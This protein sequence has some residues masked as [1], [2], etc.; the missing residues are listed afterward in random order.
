VLSLAAAV[1]LATV[2]TVLAVWGDV[3]SW[4]ALCQLLPIAR[5]LPRSTSCR[6][7]STP[8]AHSK[9]SGGFP[10]RPKRLL[11][12][13]ART[14]PKPVKAK[15]LAPPPR[16]AR[17]APSPPNT[18]VR[19]RPYVYM[20]ARTNFVL[21][22]AKLL[23]P[24]ACAATTGTAATDKNHQRFWLVPTTRTLALATRPV[25]SGQNGSF[26]P[27]LDALPSGAIER[28]HHSS[29]EHLLVRQLSLHPACTNRAEEATACV[30]AA[31]LT[32]KCHE[33][34]RLC[35]DRRL[36]VISFFDPDL[37]FYRG[38]FPTY[39]A[40]LWGCHAPSSGNCS[41]RPAF[42]PTRI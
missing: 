19:V 21:E 41:V 30:I 22:P 36:F 31:P 29:L 24:G 18:S 23:S 11:N 20:P 9:P 33:W 1:A 12:T 8:T 35:P 7:V 26:I 5:T 3:L 27:P 37:V 32:G 15:H 6:A 16:Q 17:A 38:M 2:F 13:T 4:R 42:K 34:E 39:C 40:S 14:T 25:E 28:T 10:W